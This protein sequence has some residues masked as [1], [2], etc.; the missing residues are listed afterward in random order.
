MLIASG[1]SRDLCKVGKER[2]GL[3]SVN[4]NSFNPAGA[5][6]AFAKSV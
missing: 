1:G 4:F 2:M 3:A 6:A 5:E